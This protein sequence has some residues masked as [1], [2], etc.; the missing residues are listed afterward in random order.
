MSVEI[1]SGT[2]GDQKKVITVIETRNNATFDIPTDSRQRLSTSDSIDFLFDVDK[3][4]EGRA[5]K[6]TLPIRKLAVWSH[7]KEKLVDFVSTDDE[8]RQFDRRQYNIELLT[9]PMKIFLSVNSSFTVNTQHDEIT[10]EFDSKSTIHVGA[11]SRHKAPDTVIEVPDDITALMK[12]VSYFGD[13]IEPTGPERSYATLR[14]H[15]PLLKRSDALHIPSD[16]DAP[17]TGIEIRVPATEEYVFPVVPLAHYLGATVTPLPSDES[18]PVLTT[19]DGWD[20]SLATANDYAETINRIL[21]QVFF[22]DCVT[23]SGHRF[24][25]NLKEREKI[26]ASVDL[27][28]DALYDQS[29]AQRVQ[30]YLQVPYSKIADVVPRWPL[31]VDIEPTVDRVELLP[32]VAHELAYVRTISNPDR[33]QTVRGASS[34]GGDRQSSIGYFGPDLVEPEST[35]TTEHVWASSQYPL[36]ANK[37]TAEARR[38]T[39]SG[40]LTELPKTKL[41][42]VSNQTDESTVREHYEEKERSNWPHVEF[43]FAEN[44]SQSELREYFS[45]PADLLHYNGT[46]TDEGIECTDGFLDVR[47]LFEAKPATFLL[48][49]CQSFQQAD[50]LIE[51]GCHAGVASLGS[52]STD[53]ATPFGI[54]IGKL[55]LTGFSMRAA[56]P[57]AARVTDFSK[58]YTL[59]GNGG[60]TV[61]QGNTSGCPAFVQVEPASGENYQVTV[62]THVGPGF[63]LGTLFKDK[64]DHLSAWT[65]PPTTIGPITVSKDELMDEM[66]PEVMPVEWQGHIYL[67]DEILSDEIFGVL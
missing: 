14:D 32:Y 41:V 63:R 42:I 61:K 36:D 53:K 17:E 57:I 25:W 50:L 62:H 39:V 54:G 55:L 10:L 23:R 60:I 2:K 66:Y 26:E 8:E 44:V 45:S 22:L 52:S 16:L 59:I 37:L 65:L 7:N 33:Y 5:S 15:P 20:F 18:N 29:L 9:S 4:S 28:F 43:E 24:D 13:S 31:T 64:F 56:V 67:S 49:G 35:D 51:K 30:R 21:K 58:P 27:Q 3:I 11:R 46:I 48:N 38:A 1:T 34:A 19:R 12:A 6:I 40:Q 47:S